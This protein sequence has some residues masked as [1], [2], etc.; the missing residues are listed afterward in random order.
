MLYVAYGSNIPSSQ[1]LHR[2]KGAKFIGK[3][4]LKNYELNFKYHADIDAKKG[5][6]V[7][8]VVWDINDTDELVLDMYEGFPIYYIKHYVE[9]VLDNG[10]IIKGKVYEMSNEN[11]KQNSNLIPDMNY[12]STI[13]SGY[14][15]FN[16]NTSCLSNALKDVLRFVKK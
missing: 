10:N 16:L 3:G 6:N 15:E 13:L 5:S 7:E 14:A 9:V 8:V 12:L 1:M 4:I 11:K 2:C